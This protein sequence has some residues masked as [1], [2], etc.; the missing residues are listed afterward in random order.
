MKKLVTILS[1]LILS[2]SILFSQNCNPFDYSR[3]SGNEIFVSPSGSDISGDGSYLN[4]YKSI[5]FAI[6]KS[7]SGNQITLKDG[8][9]QGDGNQNISLM[10]KTIVVQGENGPGCSIIDCEDKE[11]GFLINSGETKNSVIQG[12]TIKNTKTS[13]S[14]GY[15]GGIFVDDNSGIT[16]KH[17]VFSENK[18]GC[19]QF[20]N[21][22]VVGPE[23]L[24]ESYLLYQ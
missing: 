11:R 4:P 21:E 20:G 14:I 24:I 6:D 10:G 8:V 15:G 5:Q 18:E 12:I 17:C 13:N 16:I 23:S 7:I 9:Y 3:T 22:E 1:I 19:V 2:K